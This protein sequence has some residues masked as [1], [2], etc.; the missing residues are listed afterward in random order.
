MKSIYNLYEGIMDKKNRQ[1]VGSNVESQMFGELPQ[2]HSSKGKRKYKLMCE[3]GLK[4]LKNYELLHSFSK[5]PNPV[6]VMVM[7]AFS[8]WTQEYEIDVFV[9]DENFDNTAFGTAYLLGT[10]T[11]PDTK[12]SWDESKSNDLTYDILLRIRYNFDDFMEYLIEYKKNRINRKVTSFTSEE[13]HK[14]KLV[15]DDIKKKFPKTR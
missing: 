7:T 10:I 1:T 5:L 12:I 6:G 8:G 9:V 15:Y 2:K 11:I 4:N 3:Y 14:Q 13:H